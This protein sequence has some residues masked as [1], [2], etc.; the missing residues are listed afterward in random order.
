MAAFCSLLLPSYYSNNFAGKIEP[1]LGRVELSN[2]FMAYTI[3]IVYI[4]TGPRGMP[5]LIL[6]DVIR[7]HRNVG[8]IPGLI[9]ATPCS[10]IPVYQMG[11]YVSCLYFTDV[12]LNLQK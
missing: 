7:N 6:I 12:H 9:P 4:Y 8:L 3:V 11:I 5:L 10:V 2:G 1:S